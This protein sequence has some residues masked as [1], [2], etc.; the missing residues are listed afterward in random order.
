MKSAKLHRGVNLAYWLSQRA[1]STTWEMDPD[2]F[3]TRDDFFQLAGW[4]IDFVRLPVDEAVLWNADRAAAAEDRLRLRA[5]LDYAG[6]AGLAVILDFHTVEGNDCTKGSQQLYS[7]PAL[8]KNYLSRCAELARWTSDLPEDFLYL[9]PLNEPTALRDAEWDDLFDR[10]AAAIREVSPGRK[11]VKGPTEYQ[12]TRRFSGM[13]IPNDPNLILSFHFYEPFLFTHYRIGWHGLVADCPEGVCYPGPVLGAEQVAL[14]S[15][16]Q[17]E[18]FSPW[19]DT[20]W[21]LD[22]LDRLIGP[23]AERAA[24][25]GLPLICGEFGCMAKCPTEDRRRWFMDLLQLF[26]RYGIGACLWNYKGTQKFGM[27]DDRGEPD[28]MLL[29][30]LTQDRSHALPV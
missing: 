29:D 14:L 5:A 4:G 6:E 21:N 13:R 22:E 15:P 26:D 24:Q 23:C 3:I 9:E 1:F 11:L 28:P 2:T 16:S 7:D 25:A 20:V 17:R 8:Q 30:L 10:A 19:I 18:K 27:V 12:H